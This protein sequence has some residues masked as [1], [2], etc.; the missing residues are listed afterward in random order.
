MIKAHISDIL[1]D[2]EYMIIILTCNLQ[3]LPYKNVLMLMGM[4]NKF[5]H[6]NDYVANQKLCLFNM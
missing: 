5:I 2:V 4:K 1:V 3:V 6:I